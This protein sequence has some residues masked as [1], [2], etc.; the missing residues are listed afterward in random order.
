VG[1]QA[2]GRPK[3]VLTS[4]GYATCLRASRPKD[5]WSG[6]G[7]GQREKGGGG[8]VMERAALEQPPSFGATVADKKKIF[9]G[10]GGM[11]GGAVIAAVVGLA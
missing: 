3:G 11:A 10:F 1:H 6:C 4:A 2:C 5:P 9:Q 7:R 8:D